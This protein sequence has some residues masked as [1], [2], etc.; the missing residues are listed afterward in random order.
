LTF[1]NTPGIVEN[2]SEDTTRPLGEWLQHRREELDISLE[3]AEEK[4]RIRARYLEA[5]E[6]QDF[7]ALPDP[8]VGRGFLRNYAS[9]LELDSQEA[10]ERYAR[11]VAPPEP[12]ALPPADESPFEGPF[13]P[14]ALH[15]MPSQ[16]TRHRL[17]IGILLLLIL[18]VVI[19]LAVWQGYPYLIAFLDRNGTAVQPTLVATFTRQPSG[20]ALSTATKTPTVQPAEASTPT[21]TSET[22][23]TPTLEVSMTP[24]FTPGP[25]F[26]PS[27]PVYTGI[28]LELVFTDT[29]WVQVT[30]DGV[31]QFQGELGADTYRSWYGD[32]RVEL[33]LG[34]AGVVLV[35][36]NSKFLGT[37]GAPE[38][39]ID[40]VFEKVGEGVS[41]ATFT[42]EVS[43]TLT[44]EPLS[45]PS[46]E[47]TN[48]PPA[49]TLAPPTS[50]IASATANITPTIAISGTVPITPTESP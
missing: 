23:V 13:R 35:T 7:E 40:R 21:D 9:F 18:I 15:D 49:L 39:V 10:S 42:P 25:T 2:V 16:V 45:Q 20:V 26:T 14:V 48:V 33:R 32:D 36:I 34:N 29:S 50:T 22:Q 28:F 24:T 3:Q 17:G 6:A 8:V 5:L 41:E 19:S 11:L 27:P 44:V 37:L 31:R 46:T 1:D 4:T 30:V 47:P 38:E 12:E 43:G